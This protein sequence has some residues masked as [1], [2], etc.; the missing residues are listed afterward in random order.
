[1]QETRDMGSIPGS[2][3][4]LGGENGNPLQ[5]SYW[6]KSHGQ[7]SLMGCSW[8]DRKELDMIKHAH[9]HEGL[10]GS[11]SYTVFLKNLLHEWIPWPLNLFG[12]I[13]KRLS[14]Y[15]PTC[16][17]FTRTHF[18]DSECLNFSVCCNR[19]GWRISQ[20]VKSWSLLYD[21]LSLLCLCSHI[22]L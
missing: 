17:L 22:L 11:E 20:V 8:W 13:S 3:R 18:P 2:G 21:S 10:R 7:R 14:S 15:T 12:S 19:D 9:V 5:Y 6:K 1:M 16:F 4:S